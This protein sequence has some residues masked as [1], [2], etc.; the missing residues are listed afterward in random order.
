MTFVLLCIWNIGIGI[1]YGVGF[2]LLMTYTWKVE[3]IAYEE[4]EKHIESISFR[5]KK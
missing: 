2:V 3:K 1:G 5:M 4:T